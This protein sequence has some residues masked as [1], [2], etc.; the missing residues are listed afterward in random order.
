[1]ASL[2]E[3][4]I[5]RVFDVFGVDGFIWADVGE[6][7]VKQAMNVVSVALEKVVS[8]PGGFC[9]EVSASLGELIHGELDVNLSWDGVEV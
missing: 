4:V 8:K 7:I 6:C 1:M 5:Q 9:W 3:Q 2:V